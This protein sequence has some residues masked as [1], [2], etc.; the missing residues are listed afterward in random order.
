MKENI[1]DEIHTIFTMGERALGG[2]LIGYLCNPP[3]R[4]TGRGRV[5]TLQVSLSL[6]LSDHL[7]PLEAIGPYIVRMPD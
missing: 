2:S 3:L 7:Y 6:I 5:F 4:M 1:D